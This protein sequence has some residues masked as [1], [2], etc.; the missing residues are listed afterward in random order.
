MEETIC[1]SSTEQRRGW[2]VTKVIAGGLT[3]AE[4]APL[5][6]L[7]ERQVW[8]L[9]A[10]MRRSGP[11]GLAHGNRGR[12][13]PRRLPDL[14]RERIIALTR[15]KYAG[16]NDCHLAELLAE[17]EQILISR[18]A[19]RRLL[20]DAGL[21]SPRR[22]R[23]PRHRSR[24]DRMPQAGLLLQVDG[25]RHDWLEGRG[26]RMTLVGAID[27]ATG[28]V[29]GAVFREQEDTVGYLLVLRDTLRRYGVPAAVYRDRHTLFEPSERGLLTLEEQLA[30][31]RL[32]TQLGRAFA[33]LEIVSI[34]AR[35]PQAKG[36]IE[37]LWGT[38]QDRL[39]S[40]LR[41]AG[42][43]SLDDANRLLAAFVPRF[44]RRFAV[45]PLDATS[46]WRPAPPPKALARICCLKHV[47]VVANDHTIR[48]GATIVQLPPRPDRRSYAGVRVELQHHL[49]GRLVVW[50]GERE[51][52][53][54]RA[55]PAQLAAMASVRA[56]LGTM[57]PSV[58]TAVKPATSHPWRRMAIGR[59]K[60]RG[61]TESPNR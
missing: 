60:G 40:E 53:S 51:L 20:R 24:R 21:A 15:G 35:S 56:R 28:I 10:A 18:Q 11:A 8:R 32:P 26:P 54:Q 41:L 22:R 2:M 49:D 12:A 27:D 59:N 33:E 19:L 50:D 42:V 9:V 17:H 46:A 34:A 43:C 23:R 4:A 47:R 39:V 31:T 36:R 6:A 30:D 44:N 13:S 45:A 5:L 38:A 25:S 55:D 52:L 57:P 14:D 16:V 3:V 61:V 1:M 37:R 7:S 29:T 58:R 48:A